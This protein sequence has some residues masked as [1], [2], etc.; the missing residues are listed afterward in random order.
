MIGAILLFAAA[1]PGGGRSAMSFLGALMVA[2]GIVAIAQP[3]VLRDQLATT[4][5]LG[6]MAVIT[7][8]IVLSSAA[9]SPIFAGQR[10]A[11][12]ARHDEVARRDEVVV[13]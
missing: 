13:R 4:R 11:R 7:G 9:L 3:T 1:V 12:V 2:A 5:A 6:W 10:S 8:A